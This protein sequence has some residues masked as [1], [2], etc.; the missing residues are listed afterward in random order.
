MSDNTITK[1]M[2]ASVRT[3]EGLRN[4]LFDE[5]DAMRDGSGDRRRALAVCSLAAQIISSAKLE[6]EY[7]QQR[8][9]R[10]LAEEAGTAEL[11][12]R[13]VRLGNAEPL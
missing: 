13:T 8:S 3:G 5:I 6:I 11:P 7:E 1:I 12:I 9:L 10:G 2:P 4:L